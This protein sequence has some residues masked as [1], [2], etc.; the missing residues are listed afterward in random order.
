MKK[1][2]ISIIIPVY[3]ASNHIDRCI[4]SFNQQSFTDFELILVDDCS[5]D[6]S[7]AILR[8]H[9]NREKRIKVLESV[10]NA[11][12]MCAREQGYN[13]AIGE[14]LSFC[15]SDDTLPSNA[16]EK[17]YYAAKSQ[18]ADIVAGTVK[19]IHAD[20]TFELWYSHLNYGN[21]KS[22][23]FKSLLRSELRHNL[24][25]KLFSR[26]LF[27][28]YSYESIKGLKYFE[29]YLLMYQLVDHCSRVV[30][31]NEIVYDYYQTKGS[32][33]QL[34]MSEDR[35]NNIVL[36]HRLVF[37]FLAPYQKLKEEVHRHNQIY[38][39][40]KNTKYR[41]NKNSIKFISK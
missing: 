26:K 40:T 11:G 17:L 30:C 35:L 15:D 19:Y 5:T 6:D 29:D 10:T 36:A 31:I 22:S 39:T 2:A 8:E 20:G 33:T 9:A 38:F 24:G 18:N 7:L 16:L 25:A 27:V 13:I 21:D 4:E 14:Y 28:D 23:V 34:Q 32:S 12:P 41:S 37:D 1:P 3:N